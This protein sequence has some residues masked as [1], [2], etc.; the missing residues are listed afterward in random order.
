MIVCPPKV[1]GIVLPDG[2]TLDTTHRA[3]PI[4]PATQAVEIVASALEIDPEVVRL[5]TCSSKD[6]LLPAK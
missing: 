2:E 1:A 5:Q 6:G 3:T 4:I